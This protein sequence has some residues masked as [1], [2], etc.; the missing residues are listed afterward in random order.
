M[1]NGKTTTTDFQVKY[2]SQELR[3]VYNQAQ[4]NTDE[5]LPEGECFCYSLVAKCHRNVFESSKQLFLNLAHIDENL[6]HYDGICPISS[7][8]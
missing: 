2:I 7:Q 1:K 5:Y 4:S 8:K 6:Y 3:T